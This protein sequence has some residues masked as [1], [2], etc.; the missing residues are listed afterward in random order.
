MSAAKA[1]QVRVDGNWHWVFCRAM[2]SRK[3][4]TTEEKRKA[5]LPRDLDFF[6]NEFP[7]QEF[8][9]ASSLQDEGKKK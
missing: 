4:I 7:E 2:P 6:R 5:L 1:L 9:C 3:V 8:R